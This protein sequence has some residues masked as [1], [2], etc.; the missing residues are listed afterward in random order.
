MVRAQPYL[1]Q[2][3]QQRRCRVSLLQVL[4]DGHR[5]GQ[6]RVANQQCRHLPEGVHL[7]VARR[8]LLT[9]RTATARIAA[10]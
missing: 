1:T 4:H 7:D 8:V 10:R 6:R 3:R 9:L 2:R 5:L